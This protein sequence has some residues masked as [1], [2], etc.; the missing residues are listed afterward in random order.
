LWTITRHKTK[1]KTGKVRVVF[2]TPVMQ[3]LTKKLVR[4]YPTGPLFRTFRG[5]KS[6]QNKGNR[7]VVGEKQAWTRNGI[8]CRFKRLRAKLGLKEV[9]AYTY[10]HTYI[11][12]ALCR[13][14]PAAVVAELVGTSVQM[15]E[16]HYGHLSVKGDMLRQA[17][18][19]AVSPIQ[20]RAPALRILQE[21]PQRQ[22]L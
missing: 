21:T 9:V 14:V 2:L 1:K 12:D 6:A 22:T 4:R 5:K 19:Q 10:R 15:I 11:T 17:A 16:K 20:A 8:R 7:S 13:G 3:E 18:I